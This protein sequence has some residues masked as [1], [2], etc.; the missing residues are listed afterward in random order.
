MECGQQ[1]RK[2]RNL[3]HLT[4]GSLGVSC[5]HHFW[6][7]TQGL[8]RTQPASY[9]ANV[10]R[11]AALLGRSGGS[12]TQ[13]GLGAVLLGLLVGAQGGGQGAEPGSLI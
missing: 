12:R 5:W 3:L 7:K 11:A 4:H 13:G 8:R 2:L 9:R 10:S 1:L 6:G